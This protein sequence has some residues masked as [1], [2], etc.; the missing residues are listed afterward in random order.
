M[1]PPPPPLLP[2]F[3]GSSM[4]PP[5]VPDN[6]L[7]IQSLLFAL[8]ELGKSP[9]RDK[10]EPDFE[11]WVPQEILTA[12]SY[13]SHLMST[14]GRGL[15]TS[16]AVTAYTWNDRIKLFYSG[17]R[18]FYKDE[19]EYIRL[20]VEVVKKIAAGEFGRRKNYNTRDGIKEMGVFQDM[21]ILVVNGCRRRIVDYMGRL[22]AEK[23]ADGVDVSDGV[24]VGWDEVV[25]YSMGKAREKGKGVDRRG[26]GGH[27][28]G[29]R[30]GSAGFTSEKE[31]DGRSV[32]RRRTMAKEEYDTNE[33][34][35]SSGGN[36]A[37]DQTA[38]SDVP[39]EV[40]AEEEEKLM[41]GIKQGI[42][43][44]LVALR[45]TIGNFRQ[46]TSATMVK[47]IRIAEMIYRKREALKP[48]IKFTERQFLLVKFLAMY[49]LAVEIVIKKAY[50]PRF[51]RVLSRIEVIEVLAEIPKPFKLE[52][53]K[54]TN[55][56]QILKT[57]ERRHFSH[58]LLINPQTLRYALPK[59]FSFGVTHTY[60][61]LVKSIHP[62]VTI[63]NFI[64]NNFN[65][66]FIVYGAATSCCW[67]CEMYA[68]I[69]H[70]AMIRR[71]DFEFCA[72]KVYKQSSFGTKPENSWD[73]PMFGRKDEQ[74][75]GMAMEEIEGAVLKV[76]TYV[77]DRWSLVADITL[78]DYEV[79]G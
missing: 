22:A 43:S 52:L 9:Q 12:L 10:K 47:Y 33:G 62:E 49:A 14:G 15:T 74:L 32:K 31:I 16:T 7:D 56:L 27:E 35:S 21:M 58:P 4:P 78:Y 41:P 1:A 57:V 8:S 68:N 50:H 72:E 3:S 34:G 25:E 13:I 42:I 69:V 26:V 30:E 77:R 23:W 67:A 24:G 39:P 64:Y 76:V 55:L 63:L 18:P 2:T 60:D 17:V 48:V 20:M 40:S 73:V 38:T 28:G 54:Q 36:A 66:P 37:V 79:D 75:R 65:P 29:K 71:E 70:D 46:I 53:T 59:I 44:F 19:K 6:S 51:R 11:E 45:S 5:P 61:P